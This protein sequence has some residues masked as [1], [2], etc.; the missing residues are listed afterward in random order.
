LNSR[1][2][3]PKPLPMVERTGLRA[4]CMCRGGLQRVPRAQN[5]LG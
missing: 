4:P 2:V 5:P 1:V 3:E